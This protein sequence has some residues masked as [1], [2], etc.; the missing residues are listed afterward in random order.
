MAG[1]VLL[2][3]FACSRALESSPQL[4]DQG[5]LCVDKPEVSFVQRKATAVWPR[6]EPCQSVQG[7]Y[8]SRRAACANKGGFLITGVGR[9]GTNFL[10]HWF[11]GLGMHVSHDDDP[12]RGEDGAVSWIHGFRSSRCPLPEWTY[13]ISRPFEVAYL[14]LREPL[15]QIA[16]RSGNAVEDFWVDIVKCGVQMEP[17]LSQD[18]VGR[19][20]EIALKHYVL[21]NSFVERYAQQTFRFEDLLE[22]PHIVMKLCKQYGG[23]S[24]DCTEEK[25]L[26]VQH[27][28]VHKNTLHTEKT[29][30]VTWG[31]LVE[32]DREFAA[33]AQNLAQRHGYKLPKHEVLP[34]AAFGYTCDW[35]GDGL[36]TCN[37]GVRART[38][39]QQKF[40]LHKLVRAKD[41]DRFCGPLP[42]MHKNSVVSLAVAHAASQTVT[43]FL[44]DY[45]QPAIHD[46]SCTQSLV[47]ASGARHVIIPLRN[48]TSRLISGFQHFINSADGSQ[49]DGY[50]SSAL[51]SGG[52]FPNFNAFVNALRDT[53]NIKHAEALDLAYR[54][55]S[56]DYLLPIVEFYL[57]GVKSPDS[58]R[59]SFVC[60]CRLDED[61]TRVVKKLG[62]SLFELNMNTTHASK[63]DSANIDVH[64]RPLSKENEAW[65]R[66]IYAEDYDLYAKH[67]GRS[68]D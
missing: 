4:A 29:P 47:A 64:K 24:A 62:I 15:A 44:N 30:G 43:N 16:S 40:D 35:G 6:F 2:L 66:K 14:L 36:W 59:V 53:E 10:R 7:T 42:E 20:L 27:D 1:W 67:C 41:A 8:V 19:A 28:N 9:T 39:L 32:L 34:E 65:I 12:E 13:N 38:L 11:N 26:S 60:M 33:M 48:P 50:Y 51:N 21:Q 23:A 5:E 49:G 46:H 63:K 22:D 37:L 45:G 55:D 31:R 3:V 54:P 17:V 56:H 18:R 61:V 25:V 68:C 57:G 52:Q 58:K